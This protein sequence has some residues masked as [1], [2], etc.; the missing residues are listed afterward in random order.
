MKSIINRILFLCILGGLIMG[1]LLF[2]SSRIVPDTQN[3]VK[4]VP[5]EIKNK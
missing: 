4:I 3:V 2:W 5:L 1:G